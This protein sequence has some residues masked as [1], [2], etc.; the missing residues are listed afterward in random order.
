MTAATAL[1]R[2][3][4]IVRIRAFEQACLQGVQTREI[5]G[6]LHTAVGQEAIAAG[7]AG[8]LRDDD[9]LVSTHRNHAHALVK[10]V[11]PRAL[12]A[13]IFERRTGLCHGYGGHMHPFDPQRRFSASGIVGAS[14]P[15]ALGHAYATR[16]AGR[17]T[18]AVAVTGDGGANHG[19]FHECL[20]MASAWSLPLIVVIENNGLAISVEPGSVTP[21]GPLARRAK[22]Y[23][24]AGVTVDGADAEAVS[25]AFG[26]LIRAARENPRPAVLEAVC[27]RFRGHYEGD[28][29]AYRDTGQEFRDPL[30]IAR[31]GLVAHGIAA[32][33]L[34]RIEREAS[35]EM[36]GIL[37]EVRADEAPDPAEAL[38]HVFADA[39]AGAAP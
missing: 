5:H 28:A 37:A 8:W 15:V 32:G 25:E 39:M 1:D 9:A 11:D 3:R 35:A 23:G 12:L 13:E 30:E 4:W 18:V 29:Q 22:A 26:S 33:D 38:R 20:T 17:D 7:M 21:P 6:E 14:M 34:D 19:T 36:L 24:C 31:R 2:Y 16:L 10:G 27:D